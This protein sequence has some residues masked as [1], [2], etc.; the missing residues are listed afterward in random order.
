MTKSGSLSLHSKGHLNTQSI[1][2]LKAICEWSDT[3]Y[4]WKKVVGQPFLQRCIRRSPTLLLLYRSHYDIKNSL[5]YTL[6]IS[7]ISMS[8]VFWVFLS[9][10]FFFDFMLLFELKPKRSD[11][12]FSSCMIFTYTWLYVYMRVQI[13]RKIIYR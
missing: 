9:R 12:N 2:W 11:I 4:C 6:T 5:W 10:I 1:R 7:F 3:Y 13:L 8:D